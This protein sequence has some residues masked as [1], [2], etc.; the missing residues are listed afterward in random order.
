M[1]Q[2]GVDVCQRET[3]LNMDSRPG[4]GKSPN[5]IGRCTGLRE[6][7]R[8]GDAGRLQAFYIRG[9]NR[10]KEKLGGEYDAGGKMG[11]VSGR[12]NGYME[13]E[14]QDPTQMGE[15]NV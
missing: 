7:G 6:G 2:T 1:V 9:L 11:P 10:T 14:G 13:S 4:P 15:G 3:A 12:E 5:K 8:E